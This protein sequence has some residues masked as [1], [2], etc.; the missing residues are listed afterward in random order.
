MDLG[1]EEIEEEFP[2]DNIEGSV[3]K[4]TLRDTRQTLWIQKEDLFPAPEDKKRYRESQRKGYTP[5]WSRSPA[6]VQN[7]PLKGSLLKVAESASRASVVYLYFSSYDDTHSEDIRHSRKMIE[8]DLLGMSWQFVDYNKSKLID[9]TNHIE[10][11]G[12]G[13]RKKLSFKERDGSTY[14]V[15]ISVSKDD[16]IEIEKVQTVL[17]NAKSLIAFM[18]DIHHHKTVAESIR[19]FQQEAVGEDEAICENCCVNLSEVEDQTQCGQCKGCKTVKYCSKQCQL[20]DWTDGHNVECRAIQE[21]HTWDQYK[22]ELVNEAVPESVTFRH[23]MRISADLDGE[24][25]DV[26]V[27]GEDIDHIGA[28]G[29]YGG[30]RGGAGWARSGIR[31]PPPPPFY[32]GR[33]YPGIRRQRRRRFWGRPRFVPSRFFLPGGYPIAYGAGWDF[34]WVYRAQQWYPWWYW[35][36]ASYFLNKIPYVVEGHNYGVPPAMPGEWGIV[37]RPLGSGGYTTIP[38]YSIMA[39]IEQVC[40]AWGGGEEGDTFEFVDAS[41]SDRVK[42]ARK[43]VSKKGKKLVSK[44]TGGGGGGKGFESIMVEHNKKVVAHAQETAKRKFSRSKARPE[45][46][47]TASQ[48]GAMISE[49]GIT[50]LLIIKFLFKE[51]SGIVTRY[52]TVQD[53]INAT[54]SEI[55]VP[56]ELDILSDL[57]MDQDQAEKIAKFWSLLWNIAALDMDDKTMVNQYTSQWQYQGADAMYNEFSERGNKTMRSNVTQLKNLMLSYLTNMY[58][59][60]ELLKEGKSNANQRKL[61]MDR[62]SKAMGQLMDSIVPPS[63]RKVGMDVE[64]EENI[65]G[66]GG[67]GSFTKLMKAQAKQIA[68]IAKALRNPKVSREKRSEMLRNLEGSAEKWRSKFS[69]FQPKDSFM[70]AMFMYLDLKGIPTFSSIADSVE[71]SVREQLELFVKF[72]SEPGSVK[73]KTLITRINNVNDRL[74]R[75]ITLVHFD[76]KTMAGLVP[77]DRSPNSIRNFLKTSILGTNTGGYIKIFKPLSHL[78]TEYAV[79][80]T[81]LATDEIL[82]IEQLMSDAESV[83]KFLDANV[84]A[85]YIIKESIGGDDIACSSCGGEEEECEDCIEQELIGKNWMQGAVKHPG[86][87]TRAKGRADHGKWK[88]KG[89]SSF[90]RHVLSH[91]KEH[92]SKL[93]QKRARLALTFAKYR[94]H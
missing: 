9:E 18:D 7:E 46:N 41:F 25:E 12:S 47:R 79:S 93:L 34:P 1:E 75:Y 16:E 40:N 71:Y 10:P 39:S 30:R 53:V 86:S 56:M 31:R 44:F 36:E 80:V 67:V 88:G 81:N 5:D 38:T 87:F 11:S 50:N 3:V 24:E 74:A 14:D 78:L 57:K 20:Q 72:L 61:D 42:A 59:Y 63:L 23:F 4:K 19:M 33:P 65:F 49:V 21:G 37:Q 77:S 84:K 91:K 90:A 15:S 45:L 58:E 28:R 68:E 13:Y 69:V 70:N 60:I 6:I 83:G 17:V 26:V 73:D 64:I 94:R 51:T 35:I 2:F 22:D 76:D 52:E 85:A 66:F 92:P 55:V 89:T 29:A 8:V 48:L 27:I 62:D 82:D 43:K 54:F 32:R